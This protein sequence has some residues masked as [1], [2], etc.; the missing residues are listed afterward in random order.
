MS[1]FL[2][3]VNEAGVRFDIWNVNKMSQIIICE[4]GD[5][6]C[7]DRWHDGVHT[8]PVELK[9]YKHNTCSIQTN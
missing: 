1:E 7:W 3:V 5:A 8:Y 6:L 2:I 4:V 9:L